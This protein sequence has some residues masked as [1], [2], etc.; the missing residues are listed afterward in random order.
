MMGF[1]V[2]GLQS[3]CLK[4]CSGIVLLRM[5]ETFTPP[6]MP[7]VVPALSNSWIAHILKQKII[8]YIYM[9]IHIYIYTSD[10]PR[11]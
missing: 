11:L 6:C 1:Q 2:P 3:T 5:Q 8:V 10:L 7:W 4:N 9:Y